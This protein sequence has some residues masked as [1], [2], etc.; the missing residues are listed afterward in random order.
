M[1]KTLRSTKSTIWPKKGGVG[2]GVNCK[3]EQDSRCKIGG[4]EVG[5]G[6]VDSGEIGDNKVAKEKNHQK[7]SKSKKTIRFSDFFTLKVRLRFT[8]LRQTFI[9]ASI[10]HYFDPKCH[11]W[12]EMNASS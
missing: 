1:L 3:A 9:K 5:G 6:K 4:N 2:I 11:I 12:I 10:F 8:K 7:M